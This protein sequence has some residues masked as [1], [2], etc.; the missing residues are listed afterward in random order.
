L[1]SWKSKDKGYQVQAFHSFDAMRWKRADPTCWPLLY[2]IN[3]VGTTE[4]EMW[5]YVVAAHAKP[6][7]QQQLFGSSSRFRAKQDN[8]D[9][10]SSGES[11]SDKLQGVVQRIACIISA[12]SKHCT[13]AVC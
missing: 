7:Q 5:S 9:N 4:R 3:K 8:T 13:M 12:E 6:F 11:A 2:T 10:T 1:L